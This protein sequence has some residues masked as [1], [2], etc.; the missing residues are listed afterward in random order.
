MVVWRGACA[1][2][3]EAGCGIGYEH[4]A[5]VTRHRHSRHSHRFQCFQLFHRFR[6]FHG[7]Q[8]FTVFRAISCLVRIRGPAS[9]GGQARIRACGRRPSCGYCAPGRAR[10]QPPRCC[11]NVATSLHEAGHEAPVD[12]GYGATEGVRPARVGALCDAIMIRCPRKAFERIVDND[13]RFGRY[14]L[15]RTHSRRPA[16]GPLSALQRGAQTGR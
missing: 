7:F 14:L 5:R 8:H 11:N 15:Y 4:P 9:G 6:R 13:L 2:A 3:V 16:S 10:R 12:S 1:Q